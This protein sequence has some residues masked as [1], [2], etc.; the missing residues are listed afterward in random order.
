MILI[1][2]E[3]MK[4]VSWNCRGLGGSSKVEEIKDIIKSERPTILL[5]QETKVSDVE[6]MA[7]S[8]FWKNC[9]S[10][11]ISSKGSYEGITALISNKFSIKSM[12][13]IHH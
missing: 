4:T 1:A 6:T 8:H 3:I 9:H 7:L 11:A 12:R 2:K 5:I 10:K 13:E